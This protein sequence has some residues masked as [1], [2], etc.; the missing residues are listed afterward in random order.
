M[1]IAQQV[2]VVASD[3]QLQMQA[4]ALAVNELMP[5]SGENAHRSSWVTLITYS[6]AQKSSAHMTCA[7][8][9]QARYG[10][11]GNLAVTLVLAYGR[12]RTLMARRSSIARY[13]SA[14]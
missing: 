5:S 1:S 9:R 6:H 10:G 7:A 12:S 2:Q 8:A 4:Y 3:Y 14:T 13:A 11:L